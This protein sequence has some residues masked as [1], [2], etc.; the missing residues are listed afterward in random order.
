MMTEECY[1]KI[2]N[3]MTLIAEVIVHWPWSYK[4]NRERAIFL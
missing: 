3:F 4:S 2:V 1:T